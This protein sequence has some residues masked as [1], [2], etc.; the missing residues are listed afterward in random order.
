MAT[1]NADGSIDILSGAAAE[2]TMIH[3]GGGNVPSALAVDGS[4]IAAPRVAGVEILD[5]LKIRIRFDQPMA[6]NSNLSSPG[7]YL[8]SSLG[9]G[10]AIFVSSV[11]PE[12][13]AAPTYVDLDVN[14]MTGG[15]P[16]RVSVQAG[17][18]APESQFAIALNPLGA[19]FLF[20]GLGV[21]PTVIS[22][23]AV[24]ENRADVKFSENMFDNAAIRDPSNYA[25][26]GG[27]IVTSVLDVV[28]DTVRLV[29]TDQTPGTLYNLTIG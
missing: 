27:L 1:H 20:T 25:F 11:T 26:D 6:S 4:I 14:E 15:E 2:G 21:D 29:T 12:A 18:G 28:G 19:Q 10:V 22:V 24:G 17:A 3:A 13:G 7:N 9:A 5:S 23:A 16:Y 8:I